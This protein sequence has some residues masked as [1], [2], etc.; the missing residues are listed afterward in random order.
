M[1]AADLLN[2]RRV[3]VVDSLD[4]ATGK[5]T[6]EAHEFLVP[7]ADL[8]AKVITA[9]HV[10]DWLAKE[11]EIKA[12]GAAS[13]IVAKARPGLN[14]SQRLVAVVKEMRKEPAL[15][16]W[17]SKRRMQD[18]QIEEVKPVDPDSFDALDAAGDVEV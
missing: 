1:T 16:A 4:V 14:D 5:T 2:F 7:S 9:K 12:S 6:G 10:L 11:P 8:R 15:S 3:V 18:A 17:R 13:K